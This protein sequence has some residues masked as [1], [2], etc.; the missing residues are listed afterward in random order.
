MGNNS[1]TKLYN[2]FLWVTLTDAIGAF[3]CM[4]VCLRVAR[5]AQAHLM[6]Y[7][8]FVFLG[9]C[10]EASVLAFSMVLADTLDIYD[11]GP[12]ILLRL[13]ARGLKAVAIWLMFFYLVLP[14]SVGARE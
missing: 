5:R 2:L 12:Y 6:L 8:C 4:I 14:Q 11:F 13:T 7:F 10:I 9:V 3:F 1:V